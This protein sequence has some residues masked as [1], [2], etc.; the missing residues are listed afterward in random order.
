MV[1]SCPV[2]VTPCEDYTPAACEAAIAAIGAQFPVLRD[3][4]PGTKVALKVNLVTMLKPDRAATTHPALLTALTAY[5]KARGAFV[6]IGDGPGGAYTP[7]YLDSVYT[8]TGMKQTGAA[9]NE[10]FSVKQTQFPEAAVLKDFEYTGWLDNYD[11]IINFCKLKSHGMMGLSC[12][13]KNMFGTIPGLTKPAY[14]Y[15]FPEYERF[16]DMLVDLNEYFRPAL[17]IVDA[18]VAMEGNGPTM[19]T[20]RKVG[21]V[22]ASESP[23]AL[24]LVSANLIGL[25]PAQIPT[26]AAAIR[27]G[28]SPETAED[29]PIIGDLTSFL[30]PDFN[31]AGADA[32]LEAFVS[33]GNPVGRL[34]N[35]VMKNVMAQR[36]ALTKQKCIGCSKCAGLCPAKAISMQSGH[37][38]IDRDKC[39]RCF[40]CQE[41]CPAGALE[42]KRSPMGDLLLKLTQK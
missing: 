15:R 41:F 12:A 6:T 36:P 39:I 21:A 8:A 27:R 34:A 19:G 1:L 42:S 13:V 31:T 22:L 11:L 40:C 23:Y 7:R 14:H 4:A 28:L 35:R 3:I 38:R 10:D 25:T 37:P 9:L 26:L 24:D 17:H 32:G 2:M 30:V 18:V 5:L 33:N 29:V 16:A 20:P